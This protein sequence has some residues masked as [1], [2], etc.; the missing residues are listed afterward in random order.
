M[1]YHKFIKWFNRN[2]PSLAGCWL[3]LSMPRKGFNIVWFHFWVLSTGRTQVW[4]WSELLPYL[5]ARHI[6]TLRMCLVKVIVPSRLRK[7]DVHYTNI[8]TFKI[9]LMHTCTYVSWLALSRTYTMKVEIKVS[10]RA[11]KW[12]INLLETFMTDFKFRYLELWIWNTIIVLLLYLS[13]SSVFHV[14]NSSINCN[15]QLY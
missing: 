15:Q 13:V 12:L 2:S 6:L 10:L 1:D 5:C 8:C 7:G 14:Q 9:I 4:C 3:D 11:A